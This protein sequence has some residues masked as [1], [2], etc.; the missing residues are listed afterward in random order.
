MS[1]PGNTGGGP[2]LFPILYLLRKFRERRR[3]RRLNTTDERRPPTDA[4]DS[5][6]RDQ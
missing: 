5:A 1:D 2:Q 4:T 3:Q 6:D